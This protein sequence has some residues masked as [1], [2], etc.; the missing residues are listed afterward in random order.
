M[1]KQTINIGSSANDKTG[2][3]LRTA[4]SKVNANFTELYA[5]TG[6][7]E[8]VQELVQD[9]AVPLLTH[10][11]HSGISF[12]YD[13]VLNKI[14]ATVSVIPTQ[15]GNSGRYLSTNGATASWE[16]IATDTISNISA[17][18][19]LQASS[20]RLIA[21]S[22][23]RYELFN[24]S[25]FGEDNT[26]TTALSSMTGGKLIL[27]TT[28]SLNTVRDWEFSDAGNFKLPAGGNIYT[29]DSIAYNSWDNISGKPTIP[30][31]QVSAD[32][33]S[34]TGVTQILN[35][36]TIPTSFSSLVNGVHTLSLGS[37]GN[38][39]FPT[40]LVLGAPRGPNTVNFTTAIDKSF[41]IET[42]TSTTSKLWSFGTDGN[43]TLPTGL[44][45]RKNG[46][47]YSTITA[48]LDKVLQIETQT[49]GGVKQWSF[50][51]T[52]ALT[53]PNGT[54]K[55][56]DSVI[57]NLNVVGSLSTGSQIQVGNGITS[58]TGIIIS[59]G[60]GD[61]STSSRSLINL[62]GNNASMMIQVANSLGGEAVLTGQQ[63]VEVGSGSVVIGL[64]VI[65]AGAGAPVTTFSGWTFN[66]QSR[67]LTL[68][69]GAVI[70]E[71]ASSPGLTRTKY[72][73]TF[74]LDPTWFVTN[75]GNLIET[76]TIND[77]IIMHD[78]I[79][80]AF[81]FQYF[82]YFVPPTS[83]NY[84]FRAHA[85]E[86]FI[87]WIGAKALS[88]YTYAN[89]DMYGNYNGTF[90]E[91]QT[92]S[93]TIALTAGQFYP[94][95]IQW[96][97]SGGVGELDVFTWANDVG[98]ANTANFTGR[99]YTANTGT[100]KI[101]VNDNK[102][103]ILSTDNTT[104]NNWTFAP[105]GSLTLPI[106]VSIDSSVGPLYPKIIA[107]SG[108]L[109]S[110]QGQGNTGSAALAW[111]VDPNAASQY[112]SVAVT[113]AGGD[114]LAKVI[115]Q[116][117]SNSGS[118]GT[119]KTWRFDE[120][121]NLTLPKGSIINESQEIVTV[122][123]DQFADGGFAG[124]RVFTKVSDTLYELS[125]G[126]PN[127]ILISGIWRLKVSTST[128]YDSTDL[129]TWSPVA[130]GLPAP[131]GTLATVVTT[132]LAV[133]GDVWGFDGNGALTLP[134]GGTITE[135]GGFTGA[136]KL[137]PAGGA[138]AYQALM[139]YP[140]AGGDGDHIHLTA[141]GGTTELYLGNDNHYVKLVNGGNVE[142]RAF[143][144][145]S[146]YAT[147][148]WG[149]GTDGAVSTT[150]P[151]II[152]VPN[153]VPSSV[154]AIGMTTASWELNPRSNLATTGGSG[155]GLTVNVT[156]TGGYASAIA[157]ATAGTGYLDGEL[158]T[159]TSGSSSAS[160]IIA[161][162]GN[163]SWTFGTDGKLT[164]PG[165][166][167]VNGGK[168]IL[169]TGGNAYVESV[170][171]GVNSANSALNIFS[172]PYQKIKL[173]AGFGTQATWQFGTNGG[174]TLP[175]SGDVVDST[176]VSQLARRVEGSWTVTNGTSTYS[177]TVPM[178][179]TY[180]MWVKGNIPNGII[181]WNAT[182]S[183]SNTNVPAIGTQY[184]W[185][186]TGGG[187]PILL[188]TIPDQIRGSAG[189]ISTDATYAGTTSNRFD[190][191]ISNTSGANQT[192]Y[193]GYIRI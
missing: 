88:G 72:S 17:T 3:P 50:G 82:G 73:G 22:G 87:F 100:A 132:N 91:Q 76:T 144:P 177:F 66:G 136:I 7:A 118:A 96:A 112:A 101:A 34:S 28:N 110:V 14:V 48:D 15:L 155:S 92:Q 127:M 62:N 46:T 53:F 68:P 63:L 61:E 117:Q 157:I 169:N 42:G 179:G 107:D 54:L 98:Q 2:D 85:D 174:L 152:N 81:S 186:Y 193:Y 138:N 57:S 131:V 18:V 24:G 19:K 93:F 4:F 168:I 41:Q 11:G 83:A 86:T 140:T 108:K 21:S 176:S 12:V 145:T 77:T 187:S 9:Y 33:N 60:T 51:T 47:P 37:T 190:F 75:A 67:S 159:V 125:P 89:K 180:T 162:T 188:T 147:A 137:T 64:R 139:I 10:A 150:K 120:T 128:Y 6:S 160:F 23:I 134:A 133:G 102:S 184:A 69:E 149:F 29:S 95:R 79:T 171:Y 189:T 5:L 185:N 166:L 164:S 36:P 156:E 35:K 39:T 90:P 27:R 65:N 103:I 153:G 52:G 74:V 1:T 135:G 116:A 40:G 30:A 32:W 20:S 126:G 31:A 56:T 170:D 183:I 142:V 113:R 163:R 13:D 129:I 43:T 124:T 55:I 104:D 8:S 44:T 181:T 70:N 119:A 16:T 158:I 25:K 71:T 94:I 38:T 192:I 58:S 191:G 154:G 99:I 173:R 123:L 59:N 121:G 111:T 143:Q 148:V 167:Q 146:P 161:V 172:G 105:N 45:F 151:L 165:N 130:G 84:T 122:T 141:G 80:G 49:S 178:D 182:L 26:S 97:N 114:N 175:A 106:G 78:Y 109:F 115:L